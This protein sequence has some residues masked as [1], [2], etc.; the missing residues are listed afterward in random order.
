VVHL[1]SG[2]SVLYPDCLF[3]PFPHE[4]TGTGPFRRE[5]SNSA[6]GTSTH[7]HN[8]LHGLLQRVLKYIGIG[9]ASAAE[10][11]ARREES[12]YSR[13][14]CN[15]RATQPAAPPRRKTARYIFKTRCSSP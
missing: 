13:E 12:A 2:P 1:H 11:M 4:T 6:G 9:I 5:P 7:E 3:P 15:R 14:I 8:H 10:R